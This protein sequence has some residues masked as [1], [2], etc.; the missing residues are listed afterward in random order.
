[1]PIVRS[2][3]IWLLFFGAIL[4]AAQSRDSID[5]QKK[6]VERQREAVARFRA[7]AAPPQS[8]EP[9]CDPLPEAEIAPLIDKAAGAQQLPA[10]LLRAV[11][12]RES[13]FRPCAVSKKGAQGLMQLMP[14]TAEEQGVADAFDPAANLQAG[15]RFLRQLLE[16]YRGD[17]TLSLAAYNAGPAAVDEIKGIPD[18]P[19]T[20]EYVEA[21]VGQLGIKRIDL[22]S[23]PTPKPTGN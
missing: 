15:A 2:V 9:A 11:A 21:I 13:A 17:L 12:A 3:K 4:A 10:K 23:A 22:P 7:P 5:A 18:I 14:S 1:M 8:P 20:K 16:K 6:S 19:E